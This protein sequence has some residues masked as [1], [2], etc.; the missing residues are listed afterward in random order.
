MIWNKVG[1]ILARKQRRE[2]FRF[3]V[4]IKQSKK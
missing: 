2:V 1:F 4:E 3:V